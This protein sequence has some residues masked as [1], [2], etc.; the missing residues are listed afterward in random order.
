VI[1][2]T[3]DELRVPIGSV[4][5]YGRNPRRGDVAAIKRS[6]EVNG[7]YRPIVVN[8]RTTEVLAGN[9][10]WLAARELEWPEI[11]ATFVDVD[12]EEAARI[13][14]ADNRT[15]ELGGYD[16]TELA[17]LL[18]SLPGLEGSGWQD[19]ELERLLARIEKDGVDAARDTEPGPRP[20][21]PKTK[22]GTLYQMG[23]HRLLCGDST[24]PAAVVRL[25]DGEAIE[26]V[27]TDPPY[28]VDYRPLLGGGKTGLSGAR[29]DGFLND[30]TDPDQLYGLIVASL[31][32]AC[33]HARPG[34]AIYVAHA[35]GKHLGALF[36]RAFGDAG[37]ELHQTLIWVKN[38]FSM[39]RMDYHYQ[40]EPILYGWR[41][42]AAHRFRADRTD[43]TVI[44]D[45]VAL[46][47]L[48]RPE[49]ERLVRTLQNDL[50]TTVVREDKPHRND[51][52]P[53]MKPVRLVARQLANSSRPGDVVFEPFG[54]SGTTLIACENLGRRGRAIELDAGYCDV[55]VDRW[56]RHTGEQATKL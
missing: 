32:A 40:H 27:W 30:L 33:D 51:L 14:L 7:Q 25:L 48:S 55:I 22:P 52:H 56:Q 39:G 13:V 41:P 34:A 6:L 54:G 46:G 29:G 53:T 15:A 11:A 50:G 49:L 35:D 17:A 9:H 38:T 18:A 45:D 4:R 16:D 26:M 42:G 31:R 43:R 21:R 36:R 10:T 47:E 24:K 3:L 23:A 20:A 19:R 1:A 5:G 37:W 8:R 12:E 28:G 44:D 2:A